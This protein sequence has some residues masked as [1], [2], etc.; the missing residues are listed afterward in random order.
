MTVF[1][2]DWWQT[3]VRRGVRSKYGIRYL[4]MPQLTPWVPLTKDA[5]K[6]GL[7][8]YYEQTIPGEARPDDLE[9]RGYTITERVTY[10]IENLSDMAAVEKRFSENKRRQIKRSAGLTVACTTTGSGGPMTAEDFY[11]FHVACLRKRGKECSYK[12]E[13]FLSLAA[14]AFA[15]KS[16]AIIT[17]YDKENV[18]CAAAFLVYDEVYCYYLVPTFDLEKEKTGASARL[19]QE[20]IRFAA[21]KGLGFDFEGSMHPGIANHYRQFGSS[22]VA[23]YGVERTFCPLFRLALWAYKIKNK[24]RLP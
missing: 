1:Q 19:A 23:Y 14:A 18:P 16:G 21:S 4:L 7:W 2:T 11:D 15:H 8:Y 12:R 5:E 9:K 17:L 20:A 3:A 13:F 24:K 6:L 10:R 22:P